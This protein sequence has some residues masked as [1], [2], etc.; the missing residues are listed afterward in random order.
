MSINGSSSVLQN[1]N[2]GSIGSAGGTSLISS[3][4]RKVESIG[5]KYRNRKSFAGFSSKTFNLNG[6]PPPPLPP[7]ASNKARTMPPISPEDNKRAS[8]HSI[9]LLPASKDIIY[10]G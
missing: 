1:N 4:R 9:Q 6:L 8:I 3:M 7:T 2:I 10:S 5:N